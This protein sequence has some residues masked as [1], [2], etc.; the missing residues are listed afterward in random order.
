MDEG[1]GNGDAS[2]SESGGDHGTLGA[3]KGGWTHDPPGHLGRPFSLGNTDYAAVAS[4]WHGDGGGGKNSAAS[5]SDSGS[6]HY[7]NAHGNHSTI[8]AVD[9]G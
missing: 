5:S 6:P 3:V 8:G 2:S 9:G 7:V 4:F 1:G